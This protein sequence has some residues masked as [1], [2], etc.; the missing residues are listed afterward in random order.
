M[1]THPIEDYQI[2]NRDELPRL[3]KNA[4]NRYERLLAPIL[5]Y[6]EPIENDD[7]IEAIGSKIVESINEQVA[8]YGRRRTFDNACAGA[9]G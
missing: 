7:A 6:A 2:C 9:T 5:D 1:E 4:G 3:E 8:S